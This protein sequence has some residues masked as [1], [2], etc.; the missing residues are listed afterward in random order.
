MQMQNHAKKQSELEWMLNQKTFTKIISKFQFQTK[1]D[2]F[3]SRL[4]AQLTVFVSYH[5]NP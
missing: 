1:V 2:L 4:N 5:R 3:A